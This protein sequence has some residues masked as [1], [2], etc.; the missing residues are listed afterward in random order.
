M[1]AE[2]ITRKVAAR[3]GVRR[4]TKR[5]A[6]TQKFLLEPATG[7][8]LAALVVHDRAS[9]IDAVRKARE[10]QRAWA[11]TPLRE[12]QARARAMGKAIVERADEIAEII[13]RSTG[14]T[15]MDALSTDV[16]PGALMAS[17]YA[18]IAPRMLGPRVLQRSS[19]MFFNKVS[20]L[21][22]VPF[23]VIGIIS[24]WNF[25]LG[26]PLHE[27]IPALLAGNAVVLKVATQVQPVGEAIA[28]VVREA[29]FPAGL[30]HLV[31]LP[32]AAAADA[33]L[34]AGVDKIFITGS[35][36]TGKEVM[37]KAAARLVP[38][39]ME[40]GGNDAMIVLDDANLDRAVAGCLWAGLSN[41]G[42]S[43]A[44]V[45][46]V[47]VEEAAY[48]GFRDRLVAR[49]E[50]LRVG[51][52]LD[53]DVEVGSLTSAEQK[54]KVDAVVKD[55][56]KKGARVVARTGPSTGLFHPVLI[57]ENADASMRAMCEE[58]FGP[59]IALQK[60][61]HEQEAV[62]L[63]NNS[64]YGLS[65]SVWSRSRRR[66]RHVAARL[67]VGSVTLNDHL[68][69]HGMAETPWG[70]FGDSGIGR[71]HGELGFDEMTQPRVI[72]DDLLHRAPRNMWWYPHDRS[73]YEGLKGAMVA[74]HGRG[75]L[76]RL[77][78]TLRLVRTF[79]RSFSRD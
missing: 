5:T 24:P 72:V 52:D 33:M 55:A 47:Y 15:R 1:S 61:K 45:E 66:A 4:P 18:R 71:S 73:V 68:M 36:D 64:R 30:F 69:S 7:K 48:A 42:Q 54:R 14:K 49:V 2:K 62:E 3:A 37:A 10:I 65:A 41:A 16:F 6:R 20:T 31:H 70:G 77:A 51:P 78:G 23:G 56:L 63:A 34:A 35:C 75:L 53:F 50:K 39:V 26:I 40:L 58:V 32:G 76:R 28:K 17:Y 19:I 38:V 79:M 60:V 27:V 13:S 25:P 44:A 8:R 67:R 74:L 57:L 29:G 43:C 11:E 12:R 46:R 21:T 9:V 22:R 59:V